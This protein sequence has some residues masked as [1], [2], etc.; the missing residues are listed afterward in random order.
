MV[1]RAGRRDGA[2][3]FPSW[4]KEVGPEEQP[5]FDAFY[6]HIAQFQEAKNGVVP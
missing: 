5:G 4:L 1:K 6:W 2:A 3:C